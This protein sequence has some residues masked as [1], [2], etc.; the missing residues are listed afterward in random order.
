MCFETEDIYGRETSNKSQVGRKRNTSRYE[1]E[2]VRHNAVRLSVC[3]YR[4]Q[5]YIEVKTNENKSRKRDTPIAVAKS[6]WRL[7]FVRRRHI[8]V[9][10]GT[11]NGTCC[12]LCHPSG[13][14]NF[15]MALG[16]FW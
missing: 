7:G 12:T 6:P 10:V 1:K 16:D 5:I 15:E 3:L 4:L 14:Q 9:F 13:S 8:R 11:Q 2:I